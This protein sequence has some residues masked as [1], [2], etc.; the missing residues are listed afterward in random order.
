MADDNNSEEY[1]LI[2]EKEISELKEELKRIKEFEV[3]PTKKLS[4]NFAE[5]NVKIDRL[6]AIFEEA[7]RELK[8]EE[9]GL[10][11]QEKMKPLIERMDKVLEQN[12]QIA[13]GMVALNDVVSELKER[14]EVAGTMPVSNAPPPEP[15][16]IMI[17]ARSQEIA[18]P[19][20]MPMLPS[21]P[22]PF[23]PP[24][25][26]PLPGM[27]PPLPRGVPPP[28]PPAPPRRRGFFG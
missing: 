28:P 13:Q 14:I 19:P 16:E 27:L 24:G 25:R 7:F 4:V 18:Q 12:S 21:G 17:P 26:E 22:M 2:P 8:V 23:G 1:E 10:T 6:L 20:E 15:Q 9:G 11:F 5:L 3:Q